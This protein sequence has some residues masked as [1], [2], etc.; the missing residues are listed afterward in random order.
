MS[1]D[2][3]EQQEQTIDA[4]AN[5]NNDSNPKS[6][7]KVKLSSCQLI[8]HI[9]DT[10]D[11][12]KILSKTPNKPEKYGKKARTKVILLLYL[13]FTM[14]FLRVL[15]NSRDMCM[16]KDEFLDAFRIK[17]TN[18]NGK[19]LPFSIIICMHANMYVYM[20]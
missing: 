5:T 1:E 12:N 4:A 10:T 11:I 19:Y 17:A 8:T 3:D 20:P 18:S 6:K 15:L 9:M 2:E 14:D 7:D 13:R 16:K